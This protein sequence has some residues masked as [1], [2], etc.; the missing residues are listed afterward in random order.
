MFFPCFVCLICYTSFARV[1]RIY[2]CVSV[3]DDC[4][5][6]EVRIISDRDMVYGK[7]CDG[8]Y[9]VAGFVN[10]GT[11]NEITCKIT[12]DG[13]NHERHFG[14]PGSGMEV[15]PNDTLNKV[16][17]VSSFYETT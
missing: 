8:K 3:A 15:L 5:F 14:Y 2:F 17:S 10:S 1:T 6:V 13:C 11:G 7:T 9:S 16:L 12:C 4:C